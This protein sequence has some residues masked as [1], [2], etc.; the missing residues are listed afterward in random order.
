MRLALLLDLPEDCVRAPVQEGLGQALSQG[1]RG[2]LARRAAG[3]ARLPRTEKDIPMP[4]VLLLTL[5]TV[6][7][8]WVYFRTAVL[9]GQEAPTTMATMSWA[10]SKCSATS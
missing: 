5:V 2:I 10:H 4:V 9:A 6:L 3:E 7:A 8:I 1:L